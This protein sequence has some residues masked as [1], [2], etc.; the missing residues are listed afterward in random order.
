M[1]VV[2]AL[3]E[4]LHEH[5]SSLSALEGLVSEIERTDIVSENDRLK[6]ENGELSSAVEAARGEIR[7]L[8][9]RV[10][11]LKGVLAEQIASE[12]LSILKLSRARLDALFDNAASSGEN[13][14]TAMERRHTD[15]LSRYRLALP[16]RFERENAEITA[17]IDALNAKMRAKID[18]IRRAEEA[19]RERMRASVDDEYRSLSDRALDDKT[20]ERRTRQNKMEMKVGLSLVNKAGVILILLGV[21]ASVQYGYSNFFND[22]IK[23]TFAFFVALALSVGGE[24]AFRKKQSVFASGLTGG[25]IAAL[26]GALFYSHF[27]LGIIPFAPAIALSVLIAVAS[28]LL[29]VRYDS[30]TIGII[31]LVGGFIPFFSYSFNFDFSDATAHVAF[32]YI[33][34]LNATLIALSY[35]KSWKIAAWV[36]FALHVPC[37][38]YLV[39]EIPSVSASVVYLA[40]SYAMYQI[41]VLLKPLRHRREPSVSDIVLLSLNSLFVATSVYA[42]FA[43]AGLSEYNGAI[44]V[45]FSAIFVAQGFAMYRFFSERSV[46]TALLFGCGLTFSV[47]AIP[48]QFGLEWALLGWACEGVFLSV[49]G[50]RYRARYAEIAGWVVLSL[51]IIV[52]YAVDLAP[53]LDGGSGVGITFKFTAIL[54]SFTLLSAYYGWFIRDKDRCFQPAATT[55]VTA[56]TLVIAWVYALTMVPHWVTRALDAARGEGTAG[57]AGL[58]SFFQIIALSLAHLFLALLVRLAP[59]LRER[60]YRHAATFFNVLAG[61]YLLACNASARVLPDG[62]SSGAVYWTAFAV[63]V[64]YN[65]AYVFVLRSIVLA[66][67][68]SGLRSLEIYPPAIAAWLLSAIVSTMVVQFGL[69]FESIALTTAVLVFSLGAVVYGFV[70]RYRVIRVSGLSLVVITL[71]KFFVFDLDGLELEYR[72]ASFFGYGLILIAISFLYQRLKQAIEG[73]VRP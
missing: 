34:L 17:E 61:L 8:R 20:I 7:D 50:N 73:E 21:G 23:G 29:T 38:V 57:F 36:S 67:I 44:A 70:R 15:E 40:L 45:A 56:I 2:R 16:D 11:D 65:V 12:R 5:K 4:R 14:L 10:I 58:E 48:F 6:S 30:E 31:S 26:Y 46:S 24:I 71:A 55:V 47:L 53:F 35:V 66:A 42:V 32:A 39:T 72:I 68:K 33:L 52:F 25:G 19:E 22:W 43:D 62:A 69:G 9:S 49:V 1:D 41:A 51:S 27:V 59:F 28:V 3:R 18:E 54:V 63:L 37:V 60:K 13:A 64:A